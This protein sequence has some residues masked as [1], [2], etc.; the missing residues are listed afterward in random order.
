MATTM[1][2]QACGDLN[3]PCC[4]PAGTQNNCNVPLVCDAGSGKCINSAP[5]PPGPAEYG[6]PC[7]AATKCDVATYPGLVCRGDPPGTTP[8]KCLC[9]TDDTYKNKMCSAKHACWPG[10][11]GG[12]DQGS[13]VAPVGKDCGVGQYYCMTGQDKGQCNAM[14]SYWEAD[15]NCS[16]YCKRAS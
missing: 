2:C 13:C 6:D 14:S 4:G 7:D 12:K 9:G 8:T 5:P 1:D 3:A 10:T 16:T 15:K 11:G